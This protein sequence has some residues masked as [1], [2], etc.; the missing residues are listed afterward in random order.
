VHRSRRAELL[1]EVP[2]ESR[3]IRS[4][5][6]SRFLA[7]IV[8]AR[9]INSLVRQVRLELGT[10]VSP[11]VLKTKVSARSKD[12]SNTKGQGTNRRPLRRPVTGRPG[13][14]NARER[15]Y[16]IRSNLAIQ[17]RRFIPKAGSA[18]L[19]LETSWRS[20]AYS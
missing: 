13:D 16:K 7:T 5:R 8:L 17:L 1:P 10:G 6:N 12:C 9:S 2:Y 19:I 18:V 14:P 3:T 4:E 15:D 20:L 11:A